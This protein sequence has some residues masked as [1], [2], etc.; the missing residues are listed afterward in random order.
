[1]NTVDK[2]Y[3]GEKARRI[4]GHDALRRASRIIQDWRAQEQE[5]SQLAKQFAIALI[6][7][8]LVGLTL[9]ILI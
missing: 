6:C 2:D 7:A 4:V 1:M 5:N 3:V 8:A 9:F